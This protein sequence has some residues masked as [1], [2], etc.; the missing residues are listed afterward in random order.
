YRWVKAVT[1]IRALYYDFET[2]LGTFITLPMI[3]DIVVTGKRVESSSQHMAN[4]YTFRPGSG[5]YSYSNIPTSVT[6]GDVLIMHAGAPV[7]RL[8][9]VQDPDGVAGLLRA[10]AKESLA[11]LRAPS[12]SASAAPGQP[13]RG[14]C[15][16]CG[17]RNP[18][19]ARFCN[20][21][22]SQI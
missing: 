21:C 12:P 17:L 8:N 19:G 2:H 13:E 11:S 6:I 16:A 18:A 22:G 3:E 14:S 15:P 9:S 10:A 7:I 20:Q 5:N 4:A 1:N